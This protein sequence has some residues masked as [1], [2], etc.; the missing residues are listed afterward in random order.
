MC[1]LFWD[2]QLLDELVRV[3]IDDIDNLPSQTVLHGSKLVEMPSDASEA[4]A[5]LADIRSAKRLVELQFVVLS[6]I[7]LSESVA[8]SLFK[9]TQPAI[10]KA[11]FEGVQSRNIPPFRSRFVGAVAGIYETKKKKGARKNVL[12][13]AQTPI[14]IA[15]SEIR[16]LHNIKL[17]AASNQLS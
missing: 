9:G 16:L 5:M 2:H 12:R 1:T 10:F 7:Y 13:C 14:E 17:L 15:G 4:K 3:T 11:W 6:I 8:A